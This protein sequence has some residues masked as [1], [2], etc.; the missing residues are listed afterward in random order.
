MT[1]RGGFVR[2]KAAWD[3][4]GR[5]ALVTGAAGA[6][7]S[8]TVE[9][10][11]GRGATVLGLD[12]QK[13]DDV[14]ECDLTQP[15]AIPAAV[16]EAVERLGGLD[17]LINNAGI[18]VPAPAGDAPDATARK[19]IEVNLFAGWGVT[20]AAL[21]ALRAANG[22]VIF[23]SSG[24]AYVTLPLAASYLVSKRAIDTYADALRI[25]NA[26]HLDVSVIYPGYVPTPIHDASLAKGVDLGLFLPAETVGQVV[27][28]IIDVA[29]ARRPPRNRASTRTTGLGVA[30]ARHLPSLA[31]RVVRLRTNQQRR[32]G[33]LG[34]LTERLGKI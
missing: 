16:G 30:M 2:R 34:E 7:G 1:G 14:I 23:V 28:T 22:R 9:A 27:S 24:L 29:A 11:R 19:V 8:A 12:L 5:R 32:K 31:D 18:G 33:G 17:L 4:A 20:A 15:D 21:P 25:E 6:F 26:R 13:S 3:L 10:L